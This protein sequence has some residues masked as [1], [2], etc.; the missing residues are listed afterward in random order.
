[1][2]GGNKDTEF[3]LKYRLF[4][5]ADTTV[6]DSMWMED[7]VFGPN[8]SEGTGLITDYASYLDEALIFTNDDVPQ[9]MIPDPWADQ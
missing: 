9:L 1:L 4:E 7:Q 3:A 5:P 8:Y 2:G 6:C